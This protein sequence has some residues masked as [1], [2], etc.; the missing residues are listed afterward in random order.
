MENEITFI[1]SEKEIIKQLKKYMNHKDAT[2]FL[3]TYMKNII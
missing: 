1:G 2:K 3:N